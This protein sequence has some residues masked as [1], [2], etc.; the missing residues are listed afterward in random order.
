[1]PRVIAVAHSRRGGRLACGHQAHP[2]QLIVKVT[3]AVPAPAPGGKR[4]WRL[5]CTMRSTFQ[6][7]GES[8]GALEI[9]AEG[10]AR[11]SPEARPKPAVPWLRGRV[12]PRARSVCHVSP[13]ALSQPNA[14]R[15]DAC[16][17]A[18]R[19]DACRCE[20][21]PAP[22]ERGQL[23]RVRRRARRRELRRRRWRP[24][25]NARRAASVAAGFPLRI[26]GR[27]AH[28]LCRP[29][30][31]WIAGPAPRHAKAAPA[32]PRSARGRS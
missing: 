8:A 18:S 27:R 20:A 22:L 1:M 30:P 4:L 29:F 19:A 25:L 10:A 21:A 6:K 28:P 26:G 14:P 12:A 9:P 32:R 7:A 3:E 17:C 2:G 16:R 23:R 15:P 31:R 13:R 24:G 11:P 5:S